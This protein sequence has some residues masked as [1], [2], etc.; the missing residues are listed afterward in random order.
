MAIL[1]TSPKSHWQGHEVSGCNA[2]N[3]S[4]FSLGF[5]LPTWWPLDSGC[6]RAPR[7]AITWLGTSRTTHLL[8]PWWANFEFWNAWPGCLGHGHAKV[9]RLSAASALNNSEPSL[10]VFVFAGGGGSHSFIHPV[11]FWKMLDS[12]MWTCSNMFRTHRCVFLQWP[13]ALPKNKHV[14]GSIYSWGGYVRG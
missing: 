7:D 8:P 4:R 14:C 2:P 11:K 3:L 6:D 1:R 13:V 5:F 9:Q 10:F 12:K